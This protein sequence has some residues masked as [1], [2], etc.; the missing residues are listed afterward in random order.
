MFRYDRGQEHPG[1]DRLRTRIGEAR[2][3]V[4]KHP[5]RRRP[6]RQAAAFASGREGLIPEMADQSGKLAAFRAYLARHIED[7][8]G[9]HSP[10]ARQRVADLRGDDDARWADRSATTDTAPPA[11]VRFRDG[12]VPALGNLPRPSR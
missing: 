6:H 2:D 9:E 11:W 7:D 5:V 1:I 8:G 10:L 12:V 3:V 4:P